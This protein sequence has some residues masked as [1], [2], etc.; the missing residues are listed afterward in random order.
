M[1]TLVNS[2]VNISEQ[3]E[4]FN[5]NISVNKCESRFSKSTHLFALLKARLLITGAD[6]EDDEKKQN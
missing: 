4:F 3:G 2:L 5:E 6:T 1:R